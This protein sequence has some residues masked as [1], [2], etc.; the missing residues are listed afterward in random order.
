MSTEPGHTE[1][2]WLLD[3][4]FTLAQRFHPRS[5]RSCY[6]DVV[7]HLQ[8]AARSLGHAVSELDSGKQLATIEKENATAGAGCD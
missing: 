8:Q 4:H 7:Q 6:D 5:D 1:S 3:P 2:G